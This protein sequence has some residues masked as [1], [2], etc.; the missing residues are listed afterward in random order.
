MTYLLQL[1][2]TGTRYRVWKCSLQHR[3][4]RGYCRSDTLQSVPCRG[5]LAVAYQQEQGLSEEGEGKKL[6][7]LH[8]CDAL[9]YSLSHGLR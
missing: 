7:F 8:E 1:G 5:K 9:S 3:R 4:L 6:L 2:L